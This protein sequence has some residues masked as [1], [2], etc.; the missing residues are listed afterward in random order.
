MDKKFCKLK[1]IV[2][3]GPESTGKTMI[4]EYLAGSLGCPW[5][6]EY[7]RQYIGSLDRPYNYSDLVHIADNQILHRKSIEKTGAPMLILDTWL[8][9][10]KV[11]F[12]EVFNKYPGYLDEEISKQVIDLFLICKP[13]IPWISDRLRENGGVKRDY[14]MNRYVEEIRTTGRD[15]ILI[16]G[17]GE[18]RYHN[19]LQAVK[20]HFN[21][22]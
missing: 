2:I 11:W 4:S 22:A 3:T 16:G 18:E 21:L 17:T 12:M 9:I 1:T 8:I 10:T 19:A 14:L 6:P 13:D 20:K 7:A 5:I 15:F